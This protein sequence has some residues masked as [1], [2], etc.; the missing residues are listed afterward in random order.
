MEGNGNIS[1]RISVQNGK[2]LTADEV[3]GGGQR[4]S[5]GLQSIMLQALC[6]VQ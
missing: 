6:V 5:I 3:W 2:K 4:Q 1:M